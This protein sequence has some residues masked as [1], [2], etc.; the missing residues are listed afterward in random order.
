MAVPSGR[1]SRRQWV[2][3]LIL[4]PV[5]LLFFRKRVAVLLPAFPTQSMLQEEAALRE[6]R[7]TQV[8]KLEERVALQDEEMAAVRDLA[9]PFWRIDDRSVARQ[10]GVIQNEVNKL[11]ARANIRGVDYQVMNPKRNELPGRVHVY[12]I[13]VTVNITASMREIGRVLAE[14]DRA[15]HLL[16]WNQCSIAPYN[17]REPNKV[18]LTGT[19]SALVLSADA[20][21]VVFGRTEDAG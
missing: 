20:A 18:R 3:I 15:P 9:A 12:E 16:T 7:E 6:K 10:K 11:L 17:L 8:R 13:E 2:L 19:L 4:V 1:I 21:E 14:I 5:A